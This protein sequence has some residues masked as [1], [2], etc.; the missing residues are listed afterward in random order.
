MLVKEIPMVLVFV[1]DLPHS[2]AWYQR[3]LELPLLYQ[4]GGFASFQVGQQRLALHVSEQAGQANSN[5]GTIPVLQVEDYPAAKATLESRGCE[6]Y[7]ENTT[8]NARFGSFRDPDG[9]PLQ[10][11]QSVKPV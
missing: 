11:M 5:S 6:F 4:Y 10:I 1:S 3:T 2:V 9:N 8:P 7:F